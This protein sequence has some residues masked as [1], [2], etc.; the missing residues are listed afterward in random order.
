MTLREAGAE[1]PPLGGV[2]VSKNQQ[3]VTRMS[4]ACWGL[5]AH[6]A[7]LPALLG[8]RQSRLC[9]AAPT[10]GAEAP[11]ATLDFLCRP[12]HQRGFPWDAA[13]PDWRSRKLSPHSVGDR[14]GRADQH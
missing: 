8:S 5:A 1:K 12:R 10:A 3:R 6:R 11:A 14:Q 4:G 13:W 2:R 9:P 7:V